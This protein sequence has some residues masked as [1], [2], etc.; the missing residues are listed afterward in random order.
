L[1]R[2]IFLIAVFAIDLHAQQ[3][4]PLP[5]DTVT[6]PGPWRHSVVT[7]L[8]MTQ[9]ALKDWAQGGESAL[10]YA[11]SA[12]GRSIREDSTTLWTNTYKFTFGQARLGIQGLKKTDDKIDM[13]SVLL[14]SA[15][16]S[17]PMHPSP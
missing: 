16:L 8:A 2:Y 12:Y 3:T 14:R 17:I 11:V 5:T 10:S 7:G 13:E 1:K 15:P 6:A 4:S 9:V